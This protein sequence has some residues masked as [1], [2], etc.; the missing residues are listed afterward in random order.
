MATNQCFQRCKN[1]IFVKIDKNISTFC[2]QRK[3]IDRKIGAGS[4]D[5]GSRSPEA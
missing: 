4:V 5:K 2:V 1:T 3:E